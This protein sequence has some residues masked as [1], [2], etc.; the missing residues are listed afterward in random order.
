M[1]ARHAGPNLGIMRLLPLI[2]LFALLITA[3]CAT[4]A[5]GP[6]VR[7]ATW[8]QPVVGAEV[9]N[10]FQVAPELYRC[11]QPSK[12]G[13]RQLEAFGIKS[14]VNLRSFHSDADEIAGTGLVLAEVPVDA[15]DLTYAELV[16]ALK[17]VIGSPKPVA[18]H[19]WHGSDRTGAV[20]AGWRIAMQGWT[21][22]AALDEM[23]NGG[24]G[25]HAIYGNLRTLVGGLDA[26]R[27]RADLGLPAAP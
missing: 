8:A 6:R 17:A 19:C 9:G 3:G 24:Y 12:A 25:H 2:P 5:D 13:M 22:A 27:L 10:W 1:A 23:V 15:G 18:V 4:S 7:P 26:A 16:A 14:L 21:P 20:V 11:E